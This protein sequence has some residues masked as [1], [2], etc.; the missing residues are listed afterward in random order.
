MC[1]VLSA[2]ERENEAKTPLS[3][4][5]RELICEGFDVSYLKVEA[6]REEP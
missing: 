5:Y 6:R 4:T 3:T 1:I 2:T